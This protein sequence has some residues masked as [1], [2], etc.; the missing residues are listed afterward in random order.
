MR[1]KFTEV[2]AS[3]GILLLL[4]T[5]IALI[6]ANSPLQESYLA[7]WQ[8]PL[9][10]SSIH[11]WVN[12]GLMTVFFL[13]AGLEIKRELVGGE[14]SSWR[15]AALPIA[16]ALGGMIVPALIY[17]VINYRKEGS[18]GWGIPMATDIA[19]AIGVLTV[20]GKRVPHSLKVFLT[21]LA[22]VD[23]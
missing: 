8:F 2:E 19:F 3:S 6:L 12:D 21:A 22:I 23:D 16:G 5:M 13:V 11:Q 20:L 17:S 1:Q 14:L 9:A 10:G 4:C 15:K 18:D 7:L